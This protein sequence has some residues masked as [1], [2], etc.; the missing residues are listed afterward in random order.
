MNK[1]L[2]E[3]ML[4]RLHTELENA[5]GFRNHYAKINDL[6]KYVVWEHEVEEIIND[7]ERLGKK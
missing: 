4:I 7:I 2:S 6:V 1:D 3:L 5:I